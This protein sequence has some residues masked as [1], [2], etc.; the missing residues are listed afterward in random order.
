[1]RSRLLL[2]RAIV[3]PLQS[4]LRLCHGPPAAAGP[5]SA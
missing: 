4:V 1:M 2:L 3:C 5:D